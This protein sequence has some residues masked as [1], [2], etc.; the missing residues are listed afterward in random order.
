M[1]QPSVFSGPFRGGSCQRQAG[2]NLDPQPGAWQ[3]PLPIRCLWILWTNVSPQSS[4]FG[5]WFIL[6]KR[7]SKNA[8]VLD[9]LCREW[10][11]IGRVLMAGEWTVIEKDNTNGIFSSYMILISGTSYWSERVKT[12]SN[13]FTFFYMM[14]PSI[15]LPT[16]WVWWN[17]QSPHRPGWFLCED[18]WSRGSPGRHITD[19]GRSLWRHLLHL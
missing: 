1:D 7:F 9:N 5:A 8:S 15:A 18:C 12:K 2:G 6:L 13:I 10:E 14:N 17:P 16:G 3:N 11:G 19:V 4:W